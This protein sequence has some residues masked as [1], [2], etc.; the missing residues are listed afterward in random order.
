MNS[1]AY[2][3]LHSISFLLFSFPFYCKLDL[4]TYEAPNDKHYQVNE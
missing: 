4:H 1:I 3:K 2:Y